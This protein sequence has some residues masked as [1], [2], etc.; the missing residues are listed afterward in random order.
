MKRLVETTFL[1]KNKKMVVERQPIFV[2][3]KSNT[4]KN[5]LQI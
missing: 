1:R 5:T 4:M 3:L 2:N